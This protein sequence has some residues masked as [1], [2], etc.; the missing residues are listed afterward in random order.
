MFLAVRA[1]AFILVLLVV[2]AI[3]QSQPVDAR[4]IQKKFL[5]E[6]EEA[7][8]AKFPAESLARAD[9][10]AKRG[11]EALKS[12]NAR[13]AARHFRDARWQLP[14][15]PPGL[16]PH[17]VRVF[18]ESRMRH[19]DR[20]N[21]LAYSP[22]GT[23]VAS[24]SRDGSVKIWDLGNGREITTYRG[25][26]DQPDDVTKTSTN[27]LGVTDV[28]YHPKENVMASACGNQVHLWN[29]DTGKPVKTLLHI[30]KTD[31]PLK[32]IAYSP[33]GKS[34]AVG[35]DDGIL[36]VIESDTG[37]ARYTSPTRNA[38]IEEVVWSPNGNLVALGDSNSQVAVYAP[39]LPNQLAM[40]VQ[41]VDFGEVYG[42]A[43]SADSG[44]VFTCGKDGKA[45][46]TAG[47]KPDGSSAGNTATKL[48]EYT[49][50]DGAV[51]CLALVPTDGKTLVTG[52]EDRS[53]RLWDVASGKQLRSFQGHLT[54]LSAVTARGDGGQI[55]SGSEDGAI[56]IW[57]LNAVD[58][59]RALTEATDSLWAV[60]YSPDGKH[61]AA[62]GS[63]L[64]IRVYD[65]QTG[66]LEATLTGAKSPV[67]A[68]AFFPD[69]NRLV[70]A[71]GDRVV[72]VWD[73]A[74]QKPIKE[75]AGHES[76][77]LSVAVSDDSKQI[78]S[79]GA[80]GDR[81]V[82]GFSPEGDKAS[83]IYS[84]RSG[85]CAV[86]IRKGG[87]HVAAGLA[88]GSLVA[89]TLDGNTPKGVS[90]QA[91][92][93]GVSCVA[94]SP[95][96]NRLASVGGDGIL[97]VWTVAADGALTPVGK[98]D[99]Q[100]KASVAGTFT[101][102]T[103]VAFSPDGRYVA[104]VGADTVVRVWDIE[105][106]SEVRGLRG[107]TDWVTSVAFSPS[108]RFLASV[109][110]DKDKTLRIFEL[111]PLET[112][113]SGGHAL[114]VNA[115]AASPDGRTVATAGIDQTI[116][117]WDIASGKLI[118]TLVGNADVPFALAFLGNS[119]LVMGGRV[120]TGDTGR[121]HFWRLA[122]PAQIG[123]VTS[124][125]VYGLVARADGTKVGAWASRQAVGNVKNS[126]YEIYNAKGEQ[127]AS[128]TDKGRNVRAA[129]F[130]ADLSLAVAG[131]DQGTVRIW[132]LAKKDRVGD[133]FPMHVNE[134]V[135]V[136]ITADGTML[137]AAD[138]RGLVKI[139]NVADAR[140]REV[141]GSVVAHKA[142]VRSLLVSP[143]GKYFITVG[144]DREVKAWSLAA[145]DLKEPKPVRTWNLPVGINGLA[146][147][148]GDK[149]LVTA[150]AD[151]TAYVLELPGA[152]SN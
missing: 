30:G 53:V 93:A 59:H 135:D 34:L 5:A 8:K 98:F 36:R 66:K 21:A 138:S 80:V 101:P 119:K 82:R 11:E 96:G 51:Y 149:Q 86:A 64:A 112:S 111:P 134:I 1:C 142:G 26:I 43:Y 29:P 41:G 95:D 15:L 49:G 74:R 118:E 85:V 144:T 6:R 107:H 56:R 130:S 33:D 61:I 120:P 108:G 13:A 47:P 14:Y 84:A 60:V 62:A 27:V 131:D 73:V 24:A 72:V 57:D 148:P 16:P 99:G 124:G 133:D 42:V 127:L 104:A 128:I 121:M 147:T 48:R 7:V 25:H 67:T 140:K 152:D 91:H 35:G 125:E 116:K 117:V 123:T 39:G 137:V 151:G 150:N 83:W 75:L 115:V 9:E 3:A 88:D 22:D 141:L 139:A 50:H 54:K 2:P 113:A 4:D 45:R 145:G 87:K 143:T 69:S 68:L 38:R 23:R 20:I 97:R 52:G 32:S 77:I 89:L 55:A 78:V 79:G 102:L 63:D 136:G 65:A 114:G 81:T 71:G 129:S 17:V 122:P 103:G 31:K 90:T 28:A 105:T 46:L 18:G 40:A 10:Y 109:G 19:A 44:A 126:S 76:A 94:Y 106:K 132:D 146:F 70:S 12:D 100:A 92:I 58:E 110:V 37:K